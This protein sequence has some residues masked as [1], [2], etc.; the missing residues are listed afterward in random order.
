MK[1][2]LLLALLLGVGGCALIPSPQER[3]AQADQLAGEQGWRR[4]MLSAGGFELASFVP[5]QRVL[6]P[7]L[8]VYI[9]GD[10]F[11]W[12]SGTQPSS[13]PTPR[14]AVGLKLALAQPEPNAAYL[15]RPCQFV[16]G[17]D[18]RCTSAYWTNQRFSADVVMATMK[19]LDRLK[20]DAGAQTLTLV[21]YS[22]GGT[23]ASLVAVRRPDVTRLVTVAGNLDLAGWVAHHGLQ[24]L[25][26][27]LDPADDVLG[28]S[29]VPQWHFVGDLD[30]VVP[31]AL[32][33]RLVA[34][35]A[36]PSSA[37]VTHLADVDHACC[38][39][40]RWPNLWKLLK[41]GAT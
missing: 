29:R 32:T 36:D 34:R 15:A 11:A 37:V 33:E 6:N 19:A 17:Q 1:G 24:P 27:S 7:H 26:G 12:L 38:W 20:Q 5:R 39:A 14:D 35:Y 10:G 2:A 41:K 30:R 40:Q 18:R 8:V 25:G 31:A 4:Q 22:G 23:V 3:V 9:E 13:D 21:G 28:L 16:P